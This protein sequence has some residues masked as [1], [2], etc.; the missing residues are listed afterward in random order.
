MFVGA[1]AAAV[2]VFAFAVWMLITSIP[3]NPAEKKDGNQLVQADKKDAD[4][5]GDSTKTDDKKKDLTEKD[6]KEKE[7]DKDKNKG[8]DEKIDLPKKDDKATDFTGPSDQDRPDT[9]KV[10]RRSA[11]KKPQETDSDR[12]HARRQPEQNIPAGAKGDKGGWTRSGQGGDRRFRAHA[13]WWRG[14]RAVSIPFPSR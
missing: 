4:K 3:H 6:K 7:S 13:A 2:C 11:I 9:L 1:G 10:A 8:K 5:G 14:G 12:Q